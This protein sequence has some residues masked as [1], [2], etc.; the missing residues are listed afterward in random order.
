MIISFINL[1]NFKTYELLVDQDLLFNLRNSPFSTP[2]ELLEEF[3][4][5]FMNFTIS[6]HGVI[7]YAYLAGRARKILMLTLIEIKEDL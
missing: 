5:N 7:Q 2:K 3:K 4:H 1:Q 6:N